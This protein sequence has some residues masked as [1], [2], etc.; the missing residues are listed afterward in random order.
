MRIVVTQSYRSN[1]AAT[2]TK[3]VRDGKAFGY[4]LYLYMYISFDVSP[5]ALGC[6]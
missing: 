1:V 2:Q 4:D 5:D 3:M 6:M